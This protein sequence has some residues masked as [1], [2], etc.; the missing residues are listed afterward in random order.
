MDLIERI[1]RREL[2]RLTAASGLVLPL[3][4]GLSRIVA[5][6]PAAARKHIAGVLRFST[7]P[8]GWKGLFGFVTFRLRPVS[9][10]GQRTYH[11]RTDA[12]DAEYARRVGLVHVP[13]LAAAIKAQAAADYADKSMLIMSGC[14]A[15]RD[16]RGLT[17]MV[18]DWD[19]KIAA[20]SFFKDVERLS[21]CAE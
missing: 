20:V 8:Q 19:T 1:S 13:K 18:L 9:F 12:S 21:C 17:T 11:I 2:L 5:A 6:S 4:G 7:R 14:G 10:D 16:A 3:A 15:I